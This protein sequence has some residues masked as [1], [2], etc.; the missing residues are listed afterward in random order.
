MQ[1]LVEAIRKDETVGLNSLSVIDECYTDQELIDL[2]T[3]RSVSSVAGA[4]ALVKEIHQQ[5]LDAR[6]DVRG[7]VW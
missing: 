5:F 2:F 1:K 6:D 4:L 3:Q 7:F